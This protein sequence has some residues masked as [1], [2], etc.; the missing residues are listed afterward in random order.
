MMLYVLRDRENC[1]YPSSCTIFVWKK[2][3]DK[4]LKEVGENLRSYSGNSRGSLNFLTYDKEF[5]LF[6]HRK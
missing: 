2:H 3:F 5:R 6:S 1:I 4:Q